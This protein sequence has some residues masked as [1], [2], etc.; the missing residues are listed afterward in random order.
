MTIKIIQYI[1]KGIIII[2]G[3]IIFFNLI[4]LNMPENTRRT[5]GV[6]VTLFGVYR[7]IIFRMKLKKYHF[8]SQEENEK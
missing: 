4:P 8:D 5:I 2:F 7:L 3:I 6:I 1:I